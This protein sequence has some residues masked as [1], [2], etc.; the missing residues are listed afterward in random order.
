[1][2]SSS[3]CLTLMESCGK[4]NE[5]LFISTTMPSLEVGTVGG[6][7]RLR[8]QKAC[9]QLLGVHGSAMNSPGENASSLAE[10]VCAS[11]L[12]GELS[13]IAS[14]THDSEK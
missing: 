13:R 11:V 7:T 4:W 8:G 3:N 1:M 6:G 14:L 2:V 12:A 5:D 10:I 9:L